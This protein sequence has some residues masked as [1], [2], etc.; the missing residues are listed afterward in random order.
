MI[1]CIVAC[2]MHNYPTSISLPYRHYDRR[3]CNSPVAITIKNL[4]GRNWVSSGIYWKSY[5]K[6]IDA[7]KFCALFNET[8]QPFYFLTTGEKLWIRKLL[9]KSAQ[10]PYYLFCGCNKYCLYKYAH[11][12]STQIN[13]TSKHINKKKRKRTGGK[14]YVHCLNDNTRRKRSLT[15]PCVCSWQI[16][17]CRLLAVDVWWK[18][19]Q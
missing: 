19:A 1:L 16:S 9:K 14:V 18:L 2:L 6:N 8:S 12:Y 13:H 5:V 10:K 11:T 3:T 15:L 17:I 4:V 7:S